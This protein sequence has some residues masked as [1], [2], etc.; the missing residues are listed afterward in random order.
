MNGNESGEVYVK[1][2]K[3]SLYGQTGLIAVVL[4]PAQ[5]AMEKSNRDTMINELN[6]TTDRKSLQKLER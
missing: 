6:E 2:W 4:D 1:G 5:K 3:E